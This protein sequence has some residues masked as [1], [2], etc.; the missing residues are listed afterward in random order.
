M[1]ALISVNFGVGSAA[2]EQSLRLLRE[3]DVL[4][5]MTVL[6]LP[7]RP[8]ALWCRFWSMVRCIDDLGPRLDAA[9]TAEEVIEEMADCLDQDH[10]RAALREFVDHPGM[11]AKMFADFKLCGLDDYYRLLYLKGVLSV[12]LCGAIALEGESHDSLLTF[13][14]YLGYAGGIMDDTL[15]LLEDMEQGLLL[16]TREELDLSHLTMDSFHKPQGLRQFALLRSCWA[17]YYYLRAHDA[18]SLFSP[19]NRQ[20]ARSW[21][22]L[23][24][25]LLVDNRVAPLPWEVLRDRRMLMDYLGSYALLFD[26]PFPSESQRWEFLHPIVEHLVRTSSFVAIAEAQERYLNCG[27][28]LPENFRLERIPGKDW[29]PVAMPPSIPEQRRTISLLHYGPGGVLRTIVG[30]IETLFEPRY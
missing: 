1:V 26:L 27:I 16:V 5:Y 20:L 17:L 4:A 2:F 25:R 7:A 24:L 21:L 14:M 15:D 10:H 3:R 13:S 29:Q 23:G 19:A 12:Y 28:L 22:G 11:E 6:G 30:L 9:Q 18:T 8:A